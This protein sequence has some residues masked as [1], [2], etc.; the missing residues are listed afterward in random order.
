MC[1]SVEFTIDNEC[2]FHGIKLRSYRN[3]WK[4]LNG[5]MGIMGG[6]ANREL[7]SYYSLL[8]LRESAIVKPAILRPHWNDYRFLRWKLAISMKFMSNLISIN[9]HG[10]S[11]INKTPKN[12]HVMIM[13]HPISIFIN[14]I[15]SPHHLV[16][17]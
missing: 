8:F 14:N 4:E 13:N 1:Q 16:L 5:I 9:I 12:P 6:I 2:L 17:T 3:Y 7:F 15:F 10:H 11:I